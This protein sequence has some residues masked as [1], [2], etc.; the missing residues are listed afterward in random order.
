M[1]YLLIVILCI[2]TLVIVFFIIG[3]IKTKREHADFVK[4]T[5]GNLPLF[6]D[7]IFDIKVVKK[8]SKKQYFI[9]FKGNRPFISTFM[10]YEDNVRIVNN[11][12][13]KEEPFILYK[14]LIDD[15]T[16]PEDSDFTLLHGPYD[17]EIHVTKEFW[18]R[19]YAK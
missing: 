4:N 19:I 14:Y 12:D 6:K 3:L 9:T 13:Q 7:T 18:D 17:I 8:E 11:I 1:K 10:V 2:F 5:L 15:I 16:C